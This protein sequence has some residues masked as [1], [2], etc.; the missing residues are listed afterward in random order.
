[1]TTLEIL[2]LAAFLAVS[3]LVGLLAVS[4]AAL[5]ARLDSAI[6]RANAA[7]L[8]RDE[9]ARR[10]VEAESRLEAARH[11]NAELASERAVLEERLA[12]AQ[13]AASR[14]IASIEERHLVEIE[15]ARGAAREYQRQLEQRLDAYQALFKETIDAAAGK[16]LKD[17][18]DLLLTRANETFQKHQS[19]AEHSIDARVRPIAETL[20]RADEKIAQIEADRLASHERLVVEI[21]RLSDASTL[22]R[23]ETGQLVAALRKPQVRGRYGEIQLRRVAELAGMRE[24]CDF[25]E[26]TSTRD[27]EGALRRPDMIVR[28]PSGRAVIVDAKTNIEPYL[29]AIE[30]S[31][32]DAARAHLERFARHVAEQA[33]ALS[34]KEYWAQFEG[35]AEFVVM[36]IPGDQ[37]VDAALQQR[38]DLIEFAAEKRVILASPS[39]LIGLLRAVHVGWS[40]K[41]ISENAREIRDLGKELHKRFVKV[42][43][44]MNDLRTPLV[45]ACRSYDDL[46]ASVE[47]RLM[48]ALRKF[49]QAGAASDMPA[50]DPAIID[51]TVRAFRSLPAPAESEM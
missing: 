1:M 18:A 15:S 22:L 29:D 46:V 6:E 25:T 7:T 32:P 3:V 24:Y 34:R 39:T 19:L 42:L 23:S 14:E 16:A 27:D 5:R 50:P 51:V 11:T 30:A 36:F 31:D 38:P 49:E 44:E 4:R 41:R 20:K 37:F 8:E 9:L 13:R 35:A 45:S 33:A 47:G 48:P 40:E 26:Q 43:K 21:H 10:E 28:L 12:S 2:L 17:T